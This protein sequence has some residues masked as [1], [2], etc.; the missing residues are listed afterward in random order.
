MAAVLAL[1]INAVINLLG[2]FTGG[3]A[4]FNIVSMLLYGYLAYLFYHRSEVKQEFGVQ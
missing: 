4:F 1:V 3:G 2:V